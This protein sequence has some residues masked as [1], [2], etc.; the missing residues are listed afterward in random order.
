VAK[1]EAEEGELRQ[2]RAKEQEE[3]LA[4][5]ASGVPE[6][7]SMTASKEQKTKQQKTVG[8]FKRIRR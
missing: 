4:K 3:R 2:K 8:K 7:T 1:R 5:K 6:E